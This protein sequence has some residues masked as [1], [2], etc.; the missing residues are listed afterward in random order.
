MKMRIFGIFLLTVTGAMAQDGFEVEFN[1]LGR[2]IPVESLEKQ[3]RIQV[4]WIELSHDS[5]TKLLAESIRGGRNEL[6]P[7]DDNRIRQAAGDLVKKG[8]ARMI[9]TAMVIARSGQ[10][11]KVES[12]H[13]YIYPTEFDPASE[14]R[15]VEKNGKEEVVTTHSE[16]GLPLAAAFETRN[17][18]TTLEVDP[19]IGADDRT[20]DLNLAPEVIYLVDQ[21]EWGDYKEGESKITVKMPAFYTMKVTTQVTLLGGDYLLIGA[22]SPF[23]S[24]TGMSDQERKVMVFVKADILAVGLPDEGEVKGEK[25]KEEGESAEPKRKKGKEKS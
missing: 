6:Q 23:H 2:E 3:L 19:V 18:G 24:E 9:D 25:P 14:V 15:R 5:Y 1:P 16:N 10:R 17:V 4:E 11:A 7:G 20:I 21:I 13:E 12:I 22:N 8:D